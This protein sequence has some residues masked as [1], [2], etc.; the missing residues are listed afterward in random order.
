M[1]KFKF[2]GLVFTIF[3]FSCTAANEDKQNK[4]NGN[5]ETKEE[6]TVKPEHLTYESFKEKIW[7][8]ENNPEKWVYRG[9][10]PSVI[11]FYADWCKPCKMIAPIMEELAVKYEG[12]VNIYKIDTQSEQDLARIFQ[13]RNIPAVLFLPADG[14]PLIQ[15]GAFPKEFYVKAI[16]EKLLNQKTMQTEQEKEIKQ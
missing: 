1:K 9:K 11:D 13:I 15:T 3:L 2:L 10:L 8:F 12:K 14:R 5:N 7:D 6:K 16:E 4:T